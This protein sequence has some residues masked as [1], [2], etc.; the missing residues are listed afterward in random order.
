M[1]EDHRNA[2][3]NTKDSNTSPT[4]EKYWTILKKKTNNKL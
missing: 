4:T 2:F 3:A 1:P